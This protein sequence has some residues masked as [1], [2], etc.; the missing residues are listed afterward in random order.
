MGFFGLDE[1]TEADSPWDRQGLSL[2]KC[3]TAQ[4]L[5][6]EPEIIGFSKQRWTL[7]DGTEVELRRMTTTHIKYAV[8]KIERATYMTGLPTTHIY[9]SLIS[10]LESR[11]HQPKEEIT[12]TKLTQTQRLAEGLLDNF[13]TIGVIF[14]AEGSIYIYK[15]PKSTTV[16]KEDR[17]LVHA[18]GA[19]KVVTVVIVHEKAYNPDGLRLTWV[20]QK[21]DAE[22]YDRLV[23][24][25]EKVEETVREMETRKLKRDLVKEFAL[26]LDATEIKQLESDLNITIEPK[27]TLP[28]AS[29]PN[30][31]THDKGEGE[32]DGIPF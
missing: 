9:Y 16:K 28:S 12:M 24:L 10:E 25:D 19:F 4:P 32:D 18:S 27:E 14:N 11:I 15:V 5:P 22:Q 29:S 3:S 8:D 2:E 31:Y 23:A 21:V 13:N 17:F 20:I 30:A 6:T 1:P 7:R 26:G